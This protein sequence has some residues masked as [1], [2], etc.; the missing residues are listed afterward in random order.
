MKSSLSSW[1][2]ADLSGYSKLCQLKFKNWT[3]SP[4]MIWVLIHQGLSGFSD[5]ASRKG[6][7]AL[8]EY[9]GQLCPGAHVLWSRGRQTDTSEISTLMLGARQS[10]REPSQERSGMREKQLLSLAQLCDLAHF[11]CLPSIFPLPPEHVLRGHV[12]L[13]APSG[14]IMMG[15]KHTYKKNVKVSDT[16][17]LKLFS[18]SCSVSVI[19]SLSSH[20]QRGW[21]SVVRY[22]GPRFQPLGGVGLLDFP[23]GVMALPHILRISSGDAKR[24]HLLWPEGMLTL[25]KRKRG[26]F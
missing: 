19:P 4:F 23:L 9:P 13:P 25:S 22:L 20:H 2:L 18:N 17:L 1:N 6:E 15:K 16:Y 21:D 26:S 10:I 8:G 7:E 14:Q 12:H 11:L 24:R 5:P 3:K